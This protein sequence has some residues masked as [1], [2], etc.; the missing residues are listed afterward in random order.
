MVQLVALEMGIFTLGPRGVDSACFD[1]F[2]SDG[3]VIIVDIVV[4]LAFSESFLA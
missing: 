3:R 4:V 1:Y 2:F